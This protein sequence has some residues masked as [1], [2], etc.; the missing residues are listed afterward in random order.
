MKRRFFSTIGLIVIVSLGFSVSSCNRDNNEADAY[1]NFEA[2]ETI[3]SAESNGKLL[4]FGIDEGQS[5]TADSTIGMIDTMQL[6]YQKE[7]ILSKKDVIQSKFANII[8]QVNV[9][10]EQITTLEKEKARVENLLKSGAATQKQLDDINGHINILN[11]QMLT[12]KTQN[13]SIF[14]EL[15][16]VESSIALIDDQISRAVIINPVKGIVLEKYVQQFEIVNAGKPLYKLADLSEIILR[17]YVSGD[18]LDDF[19]IGQ[20]VNVYIDADKDSNHEYEGEIVWVSSEAEFTPKII[21][22]KKER[23]NLVYAVKIKVKNDGKIK[24]GMPGEVR[25]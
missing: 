6:H 1:G 3:I 18:Q 19:K 15:E 10:E 17:A 21:Q 13:A 24:I 16:S 4:Y 12:I 14:A 23:V 25:I 9:V 22:T 20:K 7:Q 2:I 5:L 8:A 11:K